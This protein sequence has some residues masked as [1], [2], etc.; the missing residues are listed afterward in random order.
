MKSRG[1]TLV[2]LVVTLIIVGILAV[3]ALPRFDLLNAYDEIGYR[4]KVR[5]TL[6]FARKAAVAQRR[7]VCVQVASDDITLTI[8]NAVPETSTTICDAATSLARNLNLPAPDSACGGAANKICN[9]SGVTLT[10]ST[11]SISALG[12]PSSGVTYTVTGQSA[13]TITVEAE[14]GYVH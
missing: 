6:E 14:T 13:H 5:S 11:I 8:D 9:P 12:R 2:E 3:V 10:G 7:K 1:F 4:D